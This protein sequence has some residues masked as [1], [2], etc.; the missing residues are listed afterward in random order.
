[1]DQKSANIFPQALQSLQGSSTRPQEPVLQA[2]ACGLC[3]HGCTSQG[4]VR[5]QDLYFLPLSVAQEPELFYSWRLA[6]LQIEGPLEGAS[7]LDLSR[8]QR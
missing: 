3:Q 7:S 8:N 2:T 1:M 5:L 6:Y 4:L